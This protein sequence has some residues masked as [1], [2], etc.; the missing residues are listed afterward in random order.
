MQAQGKLTELLE[1]VVESLGYELLL[2]EYVPQG[3]RALLRLYIDL[4]GGITVDDC[5]L[6]SRE[7]SA[8]L[9]VEDP[10]PGEY[11]LEVS[12]PGLD[13]PLTKPEHFMAVKGEKV[14]LRTNEPVLGRQKFT[15]VLLDADERHLAVEV[16][17][18][19]YDLA[20]SQIEKANLVPQFK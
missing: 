12:S 2:V 4:P 5:A 19:V 13:R 6:V 9:D 14:R 8:I 7:V 11:M 10:V 20:M 1:P 18:E 15:G 3:K 16:D 17:N